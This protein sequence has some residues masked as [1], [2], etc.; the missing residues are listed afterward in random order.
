[1]E[2][3]DFSRRCAYGPLADRA[4][5]ALLQSLPTEERRH[6][7]HHHVLPAAGQPGLAHRHRAALS[8]AELQP[9][10]VV[11]EDVHSRAVW[12]RNNLGSDTFC[13]IDSSCGVVRC[14]WSALYAK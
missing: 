4:S 9:S 7:P 2:A 10:V 1:M 8:N 13:H 12:A 14:S 5:V 11:E 6:Q 3:A